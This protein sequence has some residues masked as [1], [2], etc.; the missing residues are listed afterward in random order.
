MN[1]L[2]LVEWLDST[3]PTS[4]WCFLSDAPELETI[5]CVSV[6]W[7]IQEN[8]KVLMLASNIGD[9]ESGD[10]AQCCGCIRIPKV[11]ITRTV[12]LSEGTDSKTTLS[13]IMSR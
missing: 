12:R 9:Y 7:I 1:D 6:G 4:N 8:E 13:Q 5:E 10:G 2:V 3:Q 11:S